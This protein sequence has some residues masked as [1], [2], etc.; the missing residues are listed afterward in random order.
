MTV[1]SPTC[2]CGNPDPSL[3]AQKGA[4]RPR[5]GRRGGWLYGEPGG[6]SLASP[7]V[8]IFLYTTF[9]AEV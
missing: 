8:L 3:L 7:D 1:S 6:G 9:L 4:S 2:Q 5:A